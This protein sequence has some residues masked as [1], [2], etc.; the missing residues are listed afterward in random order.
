[1]TL[2]KLGLFAA[3][4]DDG[5]SML[6]AFGFVSPVK[7]TSRNVTGQKGY[8]AVVGFPSLCLAL[9]LK[10]FHRVFLKYSPSG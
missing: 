1:M 2:P 6:G 7:L 3:S 10:I 5:M 8:A 4:Q 9:R